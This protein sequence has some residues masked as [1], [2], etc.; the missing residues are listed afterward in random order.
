MIVI[1]IMVFVVM[2]M[3]VIMMLM[4][5]IMFM[6]F[7]IVIVIMMMMVMMLV[8]VFV[9][10]SVPVA[11]ARRII[12]VVVAV[13]PVV[14]IIGGGRTGRDSQGAETNYR[15]GC[16]GD[17]CLT[18]H[19]ETSKLRR[20]ELAALGHVPKALGAERLCRTFKPSRPLK[21]P[22]AIRNNLQSTRV[23]TA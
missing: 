13:T 2:I 21:I 7:M 23:D 1:M 22:G 10:I 9:V 5:V 3:V 18:E 6:V 14:I 15:G 19:S 17:D 4:V 11:P 8:I 16:D 12:A 20:T